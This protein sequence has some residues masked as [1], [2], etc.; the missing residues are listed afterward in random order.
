MGRLVLVGLGALLLVV[1]V[2][3]GLI[4]DAPRDNLQIG[5]YALGFFALW[6]G[7][8]GSDKLVAR[9]GFMVHWFRW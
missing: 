1:A 9:F 5:L 6:L 4:A 2:L 8:G 3:Y 7:F